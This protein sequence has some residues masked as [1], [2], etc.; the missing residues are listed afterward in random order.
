MF[1]RD[2]PWHALRVFVSNRRSHQVTNS[3]ST[4]ILVASA[5][6]AT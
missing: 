1:N 6:V 2:E 3:E 5:V 4:S